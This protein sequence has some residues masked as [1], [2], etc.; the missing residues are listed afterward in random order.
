[1][2]WKESGDKVSRAAATFTHDQRLLSG[3]TSGSF[4]AHQPVALTARS[5]DLSESNQPPGFLFF[6]FSPSQFVE[7]IPDRHWDPDKTLEIPVLWYPQGSDGWDIV[8]TKS[9]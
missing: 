7:L 8:E 6:F 2:S 4:L 9:K 5:A 3:L 1:M